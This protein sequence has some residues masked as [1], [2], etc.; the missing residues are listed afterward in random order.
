MAFFYK[1]L[2]GISSRICVAA[3]P[4]FVAGAITAPA[5]L[6]DG[7]IGA[8][9]TWTELTE[10]GGVGTGVAGTNIL[11]GS[12]SVLDRICVP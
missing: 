5:F 6:N 10:T 7:T 9:P 11:Y 8:S 3:C 1:P 12:F 4:A 2:D